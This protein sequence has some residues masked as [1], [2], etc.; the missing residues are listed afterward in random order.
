MLAA[1]PHGL[2]AR[3]DEVRICT[4]K[5]E[6]YSDFSREKPGFAGANPDL[7]VRI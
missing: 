1:T 7:Q 6:Y 4:L 3:P 5:S 2:Q